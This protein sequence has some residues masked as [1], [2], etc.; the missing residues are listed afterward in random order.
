MGAVSTCGALR[1]DRPLG[2]V[3]TGGAYR[4]GRP[5]GADSTGGTYRT[6]RPLGA[7]S[8][9]GTYRTDRPL[10]AVSTGGALRT[11]RP[12]GT[13]SSSGAYRSY[14]SLCAIN[15]VS[16]S[17]PRVTGIAFWTN[18]SAIRAN[19]FA[20]F[21]NQQ[22]PA[23]A[24]G[25]RFNITGDLFGF[26]RLQGVGDATGGDRKAWRHF[27]V[28][29]DGQTQ[30]YLIA[31]EQIVGQ[32]IVWFGAENHAIA[33]VFGG[34]YLGFSPQ[35]CAE[36]LGIGGRA[37]SGLIFRGSPGHIV[38]SD[39]HIK[40]AVQRALATKVGEIS[41]NYQA[42]RYVCVGRRCGKRAENPYCRQAIAK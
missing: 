39:H 32:G 31:A 13:V 42:G 37:A 23:N 17:R 4:T 24:Q 30:F 27:A 11:D 26:T 28:A 2:A 22:L 34:D 9:G 6:D 29:I 8:T 15:A 7:D 20:V 25:E 14:S 1:T 21:I 16:T 40:G 41:L 35:Y 38:K 5:L 36:P 10:D 33:A 3:S 18:Q 12:L 19:P